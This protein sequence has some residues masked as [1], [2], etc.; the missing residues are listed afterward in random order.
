MASKVDLARR[1]ILGL[2]NT[3][4]EAPTKNLPIAKPSPLN[5]APLSVG[6]DIPQPDNLP[7]DAILNAVADKVSNYSPTR[8]AFLQQAASAALPMPKLPLGQLGEIAAE[9]APVAKVV[10]GTV[11][12]GLKKLMW[13][14]GLDESSD[15]MG[16]SAIKT[17]NAFKKYGSDSLHNKDRVFD[18]NTGDETMRILDDLYPGEDFN[19]LNLE[20]DEKYWMK[21][22][23]MKKFGELFNKK[24]DITQKE[25]K[26]AVPD[27]ADFYQVLEDDAY[28]WYEEIIPKF[29]KIRKAVSDGKLTSDDIVDTVY[30]FDDMIKS[31]YDGDF[32][33]AVLD[34]PDFLSR[35]EFAI[36]E[37]VNKPYRVIESGMESLDDSFNSSPEGMR[38]AKIEAQEQ[39]DREEYF[40]SLRK[41]RDND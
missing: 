7:T 40:A 2:L 21:S 39:L 32:P 19:V 5:A 35:P 31:T 25:I 23:D 12:S 9:T 41:M 24:S 11:G 20:L 36:Q 33:D 29:N 17:I 8:R 10:P 28:E 38:L 14:S 18:P 1:G 27:Y 26:E 37:K 13:S 6:P 15:W 16:E 34:K 22:S 30:S 3:L 4:E